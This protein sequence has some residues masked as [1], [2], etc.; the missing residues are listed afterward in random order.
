MFMSVQSAVLQSTPPLHRHKAPL[1]FLYV[2][3]SSFYMS[4]LKEAFHC[5]LE[6]VFL[7]FCLNWCLSPLQ[8]I[9]IQ[10]CCYASRPDLF[11]T[12]PRACAMKLDRPHPFVEYAS[13]TALVTVRF[14][15]LSPRA[16]YNCR[17]YMGTHILLFGAVYPIHGAILVHNLMG[18]P[19]NL[20]VHVCGGELA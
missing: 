10:F 6:A 16:N 3:V 18:L 15:R 7:S 11:V 20:H 14:P 12:T 4:V 13:V 1:L 9:Q 19:Q 2:A 8:L 17:G 5:G